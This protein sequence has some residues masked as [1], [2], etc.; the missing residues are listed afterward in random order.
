MDRLWWSRGQVMVVPWTGYG[1]PMDRL[2]WSRGQVMVV[3]WTGYGGPV[4]R[5]W[6]SRG[7]VVVVPWTGYGGP[8]DG[9]WWSCGQVMQV[10]TSAPPFLFCTTVTRKRLKVSLLRVSR[11]TVNVDLQTKLTTSE[12]HK[13]MAFLNY[14][15]KVAP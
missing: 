8:M 6:W 1:G 11:R 7:Q 4:D 9:L 12:R 10:N 15:F 13:I 2:W 3:P 5:L 14:K